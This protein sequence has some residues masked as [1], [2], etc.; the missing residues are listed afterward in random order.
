MNAE[1][2][3]LIVVGVAAC[4]QFGLVALAIL[5][6]GD[7]QSLEQIIAIEERLMALEQAAIGTAR[8][9]IDSPGKPK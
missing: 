1:A 8:D 9:G 2:I 6:K 5:A 3:V 7:K 4:A